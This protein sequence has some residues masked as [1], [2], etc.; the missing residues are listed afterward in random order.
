MNPYLV[1]DEHGEPVMRLV[2][3]DY[4]GRFCRPYYTYVWKNA[5]AGAGS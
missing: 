2:E 4:Y 3:R 5:P 1:R